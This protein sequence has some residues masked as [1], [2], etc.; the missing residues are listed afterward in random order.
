MKRWVTPGLFLLVAIFSFGFS[1]KE[2][3]HNPQPDYSQEKFWIAL[4]ARH[5]I[6]DTIPPGCAIAE[7]QANAH[8]D[9]FYVHPTVYAGAN[10]TNADLDNKRINKKC[11]EC[12]MYQATPFNNCARIYAPR[13]RQAHLKSFTRKN[14]QGEIALDTAY[15]D[16]KNAF[17]YY[18][19]NYNQGRPIMLVG[20]SQGAYHVARLLEEFFDGKPLK[21]KLIAAYTIGM[22]VRADR[23]KEIS[24]CDS[25]SQTGCFIVWN[26]V[27]WG[28]DT[29]GPYKRF[30]GV[31]C[32]NPLTWT[33]DTS[34]SE[35]ALH[36]GAV[37]FK[38]RAVQP[39]MLRTKIHGTLLWVTFTDPSL[40]KGFYHLGTNYH[41][42]DINLFYMNIR[43][44]AELRVKTYLSGGSRK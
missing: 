37:P 38:F 11:D 24:V 7:N 9:V 31:T 25:A 17:E 30:R 13:Y 43:D 28:Q 19:A 15:A 23:F 8:A 44:N 34:V 3:K 5:D 33:R 29:V 10:P 21:Q 39:H 36:L 4:P 40:K 14:Q 16:V 12:V 1:S 35:N 22:D 2:K 6:G 20:H 27:L 32:V 18:L 41:V 26:S 42:S